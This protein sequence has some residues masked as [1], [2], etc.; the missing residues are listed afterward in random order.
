[1]WT[2]TRANAAIGNGFQQGDAT[3]ADYPGAR[4]LFGEIWEGLGGDAIWLDRVGFRG[5]GALPS[6]FAL[7]DFAAAVFGAA[8]GAVGELLEAA[9]APPSVVEVDR[10]IASGWFHIFPP[11][12]SRPHALR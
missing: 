1:M 5:E 8:G 12:P 9:G 10:V 7:T 6:P 4:E 2:M 3:S 11:G